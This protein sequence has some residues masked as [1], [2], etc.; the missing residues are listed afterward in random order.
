[1]KPFL[2]RVGVIAQS[3]SG[4]GPPYPLPL[5]HHS[6]QSTDRQGVSF[7]KIQIVDPRAGS[8]RKQQDYRQAVDRPGRSIKG[9]KDQFRAIING[10]LSTSKTQSPN[11][12]TTRSHIPV[13]QIMCQTSPVLRC[14]SRRQIDELPIR[15]SQVCH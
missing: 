14:R 15:K 4:G 5:N 10:G 9:G 7:V 13:G 2:N 1:M 3:C 11:S 12:N 8:T 6:Y